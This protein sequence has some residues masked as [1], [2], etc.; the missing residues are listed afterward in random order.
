[1]FNCWCSVKL[2]NKLQQVYIALYAIHAVSLVF[3]VLHGNAVVHWEFCPSVCP[4]N[5][6]IVTKWK[7]NH[8]TFLYRMEV[9][10]A[11]FY[12]KKNGWLEANTSTWNF[13]ST[14]PRWSKI[15]DFKQIIT[16]SA[17]VVTPSE[18][19]SINTNRKS[20]TRIPT[21]LRWSAYVAP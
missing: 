20:P 3:T 14:S 19:S 1:M 5:A 12:E 21:S 8:S 9:Y 15:T 13:G 18:K 6:W 17:S 11:L 16:C 2:V 10:L 7:K 4:S